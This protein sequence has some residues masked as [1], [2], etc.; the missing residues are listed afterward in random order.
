LIRQVQLTKEVKIKEINQQCDALFLKIGTYE[1]KCIRKYKEIHESKQKADELIKSVNETIQQQ[2]TY[3]RQL[4]IDEKK[5]IELSE[6]ISELK[7]EVKK[8][9]FHFNESIFSN[10]TMKFEVNKTS[11]DDECLGKLTHHIQDLNVIYFL[12]SLN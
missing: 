7:V 12:F 2:N 11:I 9:K 5:T 6:K 3:L 1:E 4:N 10:L 8:E